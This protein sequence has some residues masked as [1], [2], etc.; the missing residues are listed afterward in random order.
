M[1]YR[2]DVFGAEVKVVCVFV[3]ER[4]DFPFGV[5]REQFA[6]FGPEL[7]RLRHLG[8][9]GFVDVKEQNAVNV[10]NLWGRNDF[11]VEK[12]HVHFVVEQLHGFNGAAGHDE[13]WGFFLQVFFFVFLKIKF[14]NVVIFCFFKF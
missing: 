5:F 14:L 7:V 13:F 4:A 9:F 12:L 11:W 10:Q 3:Y 1:A 6:D 2:Q 8:D